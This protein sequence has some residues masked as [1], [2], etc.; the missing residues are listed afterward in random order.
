MTST[1]SGTRHVH[2]RRIE[3]KRMGVWP[4]ATMK[5]RSKNGGSSLGVVFHPRS[6]LD[7]P[8]ARKRPPGGRRRRTAS[9]LDEPRRKVGLSLEGSGRLGGSCGPPC[10]DPR[11]VREPE[12]CGS[13]ASWEVAG[14][15]PVGAAIFEHVALGTPLQPR[16]IVGGKK[17]DDHDQDV[18]GSGRPWSWS[19][20]VVADSRGWSAD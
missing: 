4:T 20:P 9:N 18:A 10:V 5:H 19:M 17:R 6:V 13:C 14:R 12:F 16:G 3:W 15:V 2:T 7:G 8:R 11:L 1:C